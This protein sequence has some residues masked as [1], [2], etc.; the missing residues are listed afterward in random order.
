MPDRTFKLIE[1]CGTSKTDLEGAVQNSISRAAESIENLKWFEVTEIR[2]QIKND[3]I[4]EWQIVLKISFEV[5]SREQKK[6]KNISQKD[7]NKKMDTLYM[8]CEVCG[9]VYNPK[10]GDISQNINPGTAF[11]DIPDTWKCP[12]CGLGKDHFEKII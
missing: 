3:Q 7:E 10:K 6:E 2:G 12:E 8:C 4:I 5:K 11:E 9:Y 1:V